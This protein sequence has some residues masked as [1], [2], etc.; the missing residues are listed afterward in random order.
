MQP[1]I[2][3]PLP[4]QEQPAKITPPVPAGPEPKK[5]FPI[6]IVFLVLLLAGLGAAGW[7]WFKVKPAEEAAQET[8]RAAI[9]SAV[10]QGGKVESTIRLTGTTGPE[11][12]VSVLS[13]ILR[14]SRSG[15]GRGGPGGGGG[16][17]SSSSSAPTSSSGTTGSIASSSSSSGSSTSGSSSGSGSAASAGSGVRSSANAMAAATSRLPSSRSASSSASGSSGAASSSVMGANGTGSTASSLPPAGGGGGGGGGDFGTTLQWLPKPGTVLKKGE[18]AAEFDRQ[19]MLLRLDDYKAVVIQQKAAI[20]R[21]IADINVTRKSREQRILAA[22]GAVEKAKLDLK[23][24]PVRSAIDSEKFRLALEEADANYKQTL[25]EVPF[26]DVGEKAQVRVAE[27]EAQQAEL[28]YKRAEANADKLLMKAQIDG[29]VVMMQIF[30]GSEFGQVQVGD[31]VPAGMPFMQI[32][33]PRSMVINALVNQ[34]DV[35]RL[36]VGSKAR[37][38]FDAFPDLELP[39]H[40]YSVAAMPK[41]SWSSRAQYLKEIPVRLKLDKMD[42]RVIPDLSVSVDVILESE[43]SSVVAPRGAVYEETAGGTTRFYVFVQQGDIWQRRDVE[44]GLTSYLEA[45]IKSG[46]K[47]GE[48]IALD[49]PPKPGEA[50][51]GKT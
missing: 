29:L 3:A 41:S 44:V 17:G 49:R 31:P 35:E 28:E 19:F 22:K 30:R 21:Q 42:P 39:A 16:G 23:T 5:P 38:R 13:P 51:A 1:S 46:L 20:R 2:P 43:E 6:G 40:I 48:I 7:Y 33:D 12:F 34:V 11:N 26:A 45:V 24:V 37:V 10:V 27:I 50:T 25:L 32:V 47:P 15:F 8:A 4:P 14:G 36:R 9:R 18:K